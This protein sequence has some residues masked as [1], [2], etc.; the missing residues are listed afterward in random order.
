M[1]TNLTCSTTGKDDK[2]AISYN[3]YN[4]KDVRMKECSVF[5]MC[6]FEPSSRVITLKDNVTMTSN[7]TNHTDDF[8]SPGNVI[9]K[10]MASSN[11]S[12][13]D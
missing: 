9:T 5:Y 2:K 3:S 10:S 8:K 1:N 13:I 12:N 4:N 7:G 11:T 6:T